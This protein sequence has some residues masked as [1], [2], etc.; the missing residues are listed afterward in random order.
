MNKIL[1]IVSVFAFIVLLM[2]MF[3]TSPSQVG[4]VGVLVFFTISYLFF[5]GL[6]VLGCKLFFLLRGKLNRAKAAGNIEK[7]SLRYGMV[8][9]I[10]PVA[11][12]LAGSLSGIT[13]WEVLLIGIL[14]IL[15]CFL[16]S[17][18]VI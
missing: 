14:E 8:V 9:A 10:A 11:L 18:N 16:T 12:L 17:R 13:V 3:L 2:M 4:P 5:L 7:K 6:A 15:L 1:L